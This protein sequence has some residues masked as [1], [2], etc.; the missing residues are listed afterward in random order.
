MDYKEFFLT[1]NGSGWKNR[2]D[3]LQKKEPIVYESLKKFIN[4]NKLGDLPFIQQVWHFMNNDPNRKMCP[5]CTNPVNFKSS[6]RKGYSEFCSLKCT[7]SNPEELNRR[8]R[9]TLNERYGVDYFP[10]HPSFIPKRKKTKLELYGNEEY[11]NMEKN[12]A[13]KERLYGDKLYFNRTKQAATLRNN[14]SRLSIG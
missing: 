3:L 9:V 7:N 8:A 14:L 4:E 10:H 11:N 5:V 1:N 2:A 6:L 12:Y 13:T